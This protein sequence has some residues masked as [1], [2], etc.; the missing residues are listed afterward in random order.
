MKLTGKS[1]SPIQIVS[2]SKNTDL[3]R[4]WAEIDLGALRYNLQLAK[5]LARGGEI[6]AV[7]KADAYGHGLVRVVETLADE[8]RW[9]GVANVVEGLEVAGHAPGK[10]FVLGPVLP[11]ERETVARQGFV[12]AISSWEEALAFEAVGTSVKA[13]LAIDTGMGRMGCLECEAPELVRQIRGLRHVQL[14]GV[15]TH[16]PSAD[17]DPDFTDRQIEMMKHLVA[18]L[19]DMAEIHLSNSAG[20]M[21]FVDSQSFVSL[22]RPGLMLYGLSPFPELQNQLRPVMSLKSRVTLVRELPAGRGV[23]YGSTFMTPHPTTVATVGIGYGDGYPRHLSN[24][25][26]EVL[27]GGQRCPLLGRVTM[28]QIVVDVSGLKSKPE[29][30]DEVVLMGKQGDAKP[31]LATELASKAGTIAW[32]ILTSITQRVCRVET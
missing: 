25:G 18:E 23:S 28:D 31:I 9:F 13:H 8:V 1:V 32:E 10:V 11:H 15:A 24:Q 20:L 29:A 4:T 5:K 3:L 12:V 19:P 16:F 27:I 7:V 17:E 22:M 6:M 14:E 30:G 26:A 2:N 21:G